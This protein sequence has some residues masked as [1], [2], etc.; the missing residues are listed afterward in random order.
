MV[1]LDFLEGSKGGDRGQD[2]CQHIYDLVETYGRMS[3]SGD[4]GD[5]DEEENNG[6]LVR[7]E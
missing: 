1:S 4:E 2:R 3:G 7:I 5:N 6:E